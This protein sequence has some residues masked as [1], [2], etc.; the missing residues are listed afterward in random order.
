MASGV[1]YDVAK[2]KKLLAKGFAAT[3]TKSLNL[4]LLTNDIETTK[5]VGEY[6]Q[7]QFEKL[8]NVKVTLKSIPSAQYLQLKS[9]GDYDLAIAG[10][11]SVFGDPINFLDI[12]ESDSSYNSSKWHNAEF[13]QLLDDAENKYGNNATKR[14][15]TL[16]KAEKLLLK[17]QATIPLYQSNNL[18]L[19]KSKVKGINYNPSGVPY[20][21]KTT[22]IAK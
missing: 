19:L 18:Q 22:Y 2:A 13:D 17:E 3:G 14:W 4:T 1:A 10:W 20:D 16:V 15:D 11:Q 21:W 8:P 12:W 7:S 9:A 6:L 5:S